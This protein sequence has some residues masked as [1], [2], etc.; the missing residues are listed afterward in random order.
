MKKNKIIMFS[1]IF[2][3]LVLIFQIIYDIG[4]LID[5]IDNNNDLYRMEDRIVTIENRLDKIEER[6]DKIEKES[7]NYANS[8]NIKYN[9]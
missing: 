5:T 3:F 7:N 4:L 8:A 2:V 1:F 9:S 6:V